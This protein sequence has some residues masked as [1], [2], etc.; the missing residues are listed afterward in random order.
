MI[1]VL[2]GMGASSKMYTSFKAWNS[3]EN[4]KFLDW[5]AWKGEKSLAEIAESIIEANNIDSQD[6][7]AGSSLG[8][9]VA[10]EIAQK[11]KAKKA[12]LIGSAVS[13]V[14]VNKFLITIAPIAK[15]TPIKYIQSLTGKSG[16]DFMEMFSLVDA[17]FIRHMCLAVNKWAGVDYENTERIHGTKDRV[18]KC[19]ENAQPVHGA[20]H[21][22]SMTHP[23]EC[24]SI[25]RKL[26]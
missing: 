15:I 2:P 25:F 4:I 22:V 12:I 10:L 14:E 7:I 20:G 11:T 8:G 9:M 5:P 21:L 17:E 23:D 19:P 3:L 18:I 13:R 26:I 1:Y 24:V 16:G 6:I